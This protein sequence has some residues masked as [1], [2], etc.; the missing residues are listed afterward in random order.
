MP[1]STA[2]KRRPAKENPF[3]LDT[4]T[5]LPTQRAVSAQPPL[6]S[7]RPYR[8]KALRQP[9]QRNGLIRFVVILLFGLLLWPTLHSW[10]PKPQPSTIEALPVRFTYISS[11][12]GPRWGRMHQGIDFAANNGAP[13]Y[14]ASTGNVIHSGWEAGYGKSVVLDHGNKRQTRYAHCSRLI[15]KVG[16]SVEK[17]QVIAKVG[18]TGHSTGPHLHFEVIVNGKRQNPAWYYPLHQVETAQLA[19]H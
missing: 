16:Q 4:T 13:I 12:F 18:S 19:S 8:T 14:A 2:T 17:G 3:R 10:V 11:L 1:L 15:A 6:P 5:L 7:M 9:S